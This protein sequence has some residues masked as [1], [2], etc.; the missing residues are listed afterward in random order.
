M[1]TNQV[2]TRSQTALIA[3]AQIMS[4]PKETAQKPKLKTD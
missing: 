3:A 1:V 4:T 2:I